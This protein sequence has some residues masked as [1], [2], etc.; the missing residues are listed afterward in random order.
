MHFATA[1]DPSVVDYGRLLITRPGR[2][3]NRQSAV[4]LEEALAGLDP[5]DRRLHDEIVSLLGA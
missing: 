4:T 2:G 3:E 1:V 5:S